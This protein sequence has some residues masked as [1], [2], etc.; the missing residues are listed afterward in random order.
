[1]KKKIAILV[2]NPARDLPACVWLS[3]FLLEKYQVFLVTT[4]QAS[5]DLFRIMPDLVLLNYLREN[6]KPL[7]KKLIR[8][9]IGFS[10]LDTEGGLFMQVP[11]SQENTYTMTVIKDDEIRSQVKQFFVWGSDLYQQLLQRQLYPKDSLVCLGTP[12][13]DFFS[14][15][16]KSYFSNPESY[17]PQSDFIL[18]NTSFAGNNPKY[19]NKEAEKKMLI[20]KYQYTAEFIEDFFK[21]LDLVL[22][23]YIELTKKIANHF[24]DK[25]IVLRPHP[26]ENHSLYIK[27]FAEFKNILVDGQGTSADWLWHAKALVHYE[28]ST[29]VEASFIGLPQFSLEKFKDL[30]PNPFIE[31]LTHYAV[32]ENHLFQLLE[33]VLLEKYERPPFVKKNLKEVESRIYH[34]IDGRSAERISQAILASINNSSSDGKSVKKLITFF[35]FFVFGFRS[36]IKLIMKGK[37]VPDGKALIQNE[38]QSCLNRISKV[39]KVNF[40]LR[41]VSLSSCFEIQINNQNEK[42]HVRN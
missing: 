25:K 29:G 30:R 32:D 14:P 5:T 18:I 36:L 16:L 11:N 39:K 7:V 27:E 42:S 19:S 13:M 4:A 37:L 34:Q 21:N 17:M 23:A 15:A 6:N 28:C 35:Y 22:Y 33:S 40:N 38:V 24:P 41:K 9:G 20:E 10:V 26:F 12:R 2:D 1:M 8:C 31:K 3:T